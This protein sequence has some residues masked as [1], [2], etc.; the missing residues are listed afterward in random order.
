MNRR[1]PNE[2]KAAHRRPGGRGGKKSTRV[3]EKEGWCSQAKKIGVWS[4]SR[5]SHGKNAIS[6]VKARVS[7][8]IL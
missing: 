2:G 5:G 8:R 4:K 6:F 7:R 3:K 1:V